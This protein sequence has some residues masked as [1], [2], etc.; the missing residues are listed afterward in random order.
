MNTST[1]RKLNQINHTFY[2]QIASDFDQSRQHFWPG[3][4]QL[5][6]HLQELQLRR[7]T[8]NVLDLGCGNGRFAEFLLEVLSP[9]PFTYTGIDTNEEFLKITRA[10]LDKNQVNHTVFALDLVESL[11]AHSFSSKFTHSGYSL[12]S[13]LGVIHHIPSRQLRQDLLSSALTLLDTGG[14]LVLASWQFTE[15]GRFRDK[16]VDPTKILQEQDIMPTQLEE[17]DYFMTWER[18][19]HSVRYCHYTNEAEL[20]EL[21]TP[22]LTS[23]EYQLLTTFRADGRENSANLYLVIQKR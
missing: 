9:K 16:L 19:Q 23:N 6:P 14:L 3:W 5:Q 4:Y 2:S 18:G 8:L 17:N 22:A 10:K 12:I 7:S 13:I 21:L 1:I 11:L 20:L 15:Y